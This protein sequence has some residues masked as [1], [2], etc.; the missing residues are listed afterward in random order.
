MGIYRINRTIKAVIFLPYAV[1]HFRIILPLFKRHAWR[2]EFGIVF[3]PLVIFVHALIKSSRI[4]RR[5][6]YFE[7]RI[8][9]LPDFPSP[10]IV[11]YPVAGIQLPV[12]K[13]FPFRMCVF[14]TNRFIIR[15]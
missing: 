9:R 8:Y 3:S 7:N 2:I 1:F 15:Q 13:F 4:Y 10:V 11:N 14:G 6:I 5:R 12:N